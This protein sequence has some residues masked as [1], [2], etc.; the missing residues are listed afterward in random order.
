MTNKPVI[1]IA[2]CGNMGLP[3]SQQLRKHG[4]D[5]W[6]FDVRPVHEFGDFQDRMVEDPKE[7]A[8]RVDVVFSIVRDTRQ[9]E[10]LLFDVQ[11]LYAQPNPPKTLIISST[12]SPRFL[13]T[14]RARLPQDVLL[15]D[16]P[17]SGTEFKAKDGTLT[18]MV[19]GPDDTVRD[20]MPV[21]EAMGT[22]IHHLGPLGSGLTCKVIN[23]FVAASNIIAVRHAL[24]TSEKLGVDR[25][26]ILKV[27]SSS[28]GTNWYAQYFKEIDWSLEAYDPANTMGIVKKDVASYLDAVEGIEGRDITDFESLVHSEMGLIKALDP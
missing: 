12:I 5:N 21:F 23:N 2:G 16:A 9:T 7:F 3:M 22:T 4:F 15:I 26:T 11:A 18:F 27:I 25:D 13:T 14:L 20:L 8:D 19:G 28:S 10:D 17:M 6:G 24:E 1:G